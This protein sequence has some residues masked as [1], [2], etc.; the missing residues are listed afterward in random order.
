MK[1]NKKI[2]PTNAHLK[3]SLMRKKKSEIRSRGLFS[4]NR[5]RLVCSCKTNIVGLTFSFLNIISKCATMASKPTKTLC[6]LSIL[7]VTIHNAASVKNVLLLLADDA[8]FEMGAYLN[9]YCQTPNLDALAKDGLLFNNAFTSVSSCSPSRA[10]LLTGQAS[11]QNGM[12]GL[13]QGVHNFNVFK[14]VTSLPN[15]LRAN[16]NVLTGIIGKKHVGAEGN[17]Q[18]DYEQTEENHSINQIGRNITNIKLYVKDF[19]NRTQHEQKPFF[20][21]VAFHDPHRCGHITPQY[22]EFCE[23]YG[24]GEEGMGVIPDWRPIYYDWRNLKIPDW[25]PQ[26]ETVQKELAAQYMTISR[27]DQGVGVVLKE[28]RSIGLDKDTLV[29]YTSDNGP[30]FPSGRANLYDRGVREP[31]IL[32]SPDS[33]KRRNQVTSAMTSLLDV[34]PTVLDVFGMKPSNPSLTG[35]SLLPLLD[36]EPQPNEN[37]T[38]YGS[39]NFHEITMNY[40]MR[41]IRTRRYKLIHNL[42]FWSY[43]PIDQDLY[44]SPTFQEILNATM[45]KQ[46]LPWVKTL[47]SY[48]KRPE[49]ELYDLK[50]DSLERWNLATKAKFKDLLRNLK[51]RLF[52]WQVETSDPWRCSPHAVLQEQGIYKKN[53]VCLT[54]G[55]EDL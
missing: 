40:P 53:P 12:Y 16:G 46:K 47:Q 49:W 7:L 27:L 35:K 55:H 10:Q 5:F 28:L 44:T 23:R 52:R 54:L 18:F 45:M 21:V 19:L 33:G 13:H 2:P 30:P 4:R 42:N 38:I 17:F 22:G 36:N 14:T 20:L 50:M 1:S 9:K 37:E 34:F 26:T 11:H 25:M 41:M 24:S 48:Y 43:F 6:F 3:L 51:E 32:S 29:M 8:G 39:Q 31:M 15:I